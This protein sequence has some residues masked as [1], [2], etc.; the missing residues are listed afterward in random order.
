MSAIKGLL[1]ES[2]AKDSVA[3]Q[4]GLLASDLV[5]RIDGRE[6]GSAEDLYDYIYTQATSDTVTLDVLRSGRPVRLKLK[7]Y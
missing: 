2:V 6:I 3:E 1:V 5:L 4:A 7:V